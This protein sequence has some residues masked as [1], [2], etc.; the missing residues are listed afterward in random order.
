MLEAFDPAGGGRGQAGLAGRQ[1]AG[2]PAL[3]ARAGH[4]VAVGLWQRA[5]GRRAGDLAVCA[6]LAWS[7]FRVVLPIWDKALP[8]VVACL[9]AALRRFGGVP[10][11][12]LTDNE[13]TVT[14]EHVAHRVTRRAP[15]AMLAEEGARLHA[16]PA[17]PFTLAFGQTRTVGSTS[18]M[19]DFQIGQ[20]S[21]PH[22][23]RG[24]VV[25]VREHG[26]E[27]V[28]V[29]VGPTGPVE[30][31]RHARATPGSPRLDDAHFPPQP[32][33]PLARI[34]RA[35]S[36]AEA[37]FLAIGDG[38]RCGLPRRPGRDRRQRAAA[39]RLRRRRGPV[40]A[41][42]RRLRAA[43]CGRQLQPPGLDPDSTSSCQRR[44]P[45]RPWTD[46][47]TTPTCASPGATRC[48]SARPPRASG[49]CR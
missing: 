34:P 17:A 49:W 18:P 31:P 39:G 35:Q 10:T 22:T 30:V 4:V 25:W 7:R 41:G 23:L 44:L 1:P 11:Y 33:G 47:S 5:D 21:V 29:H 36:S 13:K 37:E 6:W 26:E 42:R 2:L 46:C 19:I 8:S 14:V 16:L 9:D 32:A 15:V 24:E 48:G 20:Y 27:I 38:P 40:P 28:V 45:P 43:Q 12:G 3:G